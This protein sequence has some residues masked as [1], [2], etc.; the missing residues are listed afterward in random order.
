[1]RSRFRCLLPLMVLGLLTPTNAAAAQ[2][3]DAFD[4]PKVFGPLTLDTRNCGR[5]QTANTVGDVVAGAKSCLSFYLLDPAAD[6]NP[7]RD[8]GII[9][10]QTNVNA[11]RNWCT[12]SVRGAIHVPRRARLH[13]H[14]PTTKR[15]SGKRQVLTRLVATAQD[16]AHRVA[17]IRRR[18]LLYSE[19]LRGRPRD[20]RR[21]F[22]IRWRGSSTA[23]LAFVSAIEVSWRSGLG[24][25]RSVRSTLNYQVHF[26]R[27]C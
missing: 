3:L 24:P 2:Q 23:K 14:S 10:V 19:V 22:Q 4:R 7:R 12:T 18:Y 26:G 8:Y 17:K 16:P 25:P 27:D 6:I 9:W 11:R 20:A 21:S 13:A 1:M 15:A 5:R